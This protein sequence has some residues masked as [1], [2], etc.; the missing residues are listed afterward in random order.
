M[1]SLASAYAETVRLFPLLQKRAKALAEKRASLHCK[2]LLAPVAVQSPLPLPGELAQLAALAVAAGG[3]LLGP[4][5]V[6]SAAASPA[7]YVRP[8]VPLAE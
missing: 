1:S 4:D 7:Q 3:A 8:L 6:A 2:G 5:V